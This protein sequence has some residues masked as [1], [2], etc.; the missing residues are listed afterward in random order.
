MEAR[1]DVFR[2]SVNLIVALSEVKALKG[3]EMSFE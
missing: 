3:V 2:W 1:K